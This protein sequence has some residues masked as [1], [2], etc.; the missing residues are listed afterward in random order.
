MIPGELEQ[1]ILDH[2]DP[3]NPL[4]ATMTRDAQANLL[5]P[6]MISGHIQASFIKMACRMTSAE[7]ILEI[8]TFTGYTTLAIAET[9][10]EK[11]RIDTI[12]IDDEMEPFIMRYFSIS[13]HKHKIR[14]HI[15]DALDII[16]GLDGGYDLVFIDADKRKYKEY[17]GL[18]FDKVR[19]GGVILADNTL[20]SGKVL[21]Y[22]S[23]SDKQTI[24]IREFNDYVAADKRVEKTI[25]P[26]RDGL[27][28]IWKKQEDYG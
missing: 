20:W 16:P 4:L 27:T 17:Y 23:P 22:P 5:R 7:R 24:G 13:P 15:G 12:E 3:E 28:I 2:S 8:G 6:R 18:V 14:L 26:L 21:K 10:S 9:L 25:L 1:Y 11:G 19:K